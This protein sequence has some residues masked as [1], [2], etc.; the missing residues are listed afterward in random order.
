MARNM[1]CE[2]KG[3]NQWTFK[4]EEIPSKRSDY[5]PVKLF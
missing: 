3:S 5:N 1:F 4:F 2:V